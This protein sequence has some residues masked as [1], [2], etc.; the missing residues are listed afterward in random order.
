MKVCLLTSTYPLNSNDG[1]GHF[2]KSIA[3][4]LAGLGHEVHVVTPF[5][6]ELQAQDGK[7]QLHP[8]R[9]I[10]PDRWAIMGYGKSLFSDRSLRWGTYLL[11][12]VFFA[13]AVIKIIRLH[14]RYHFEI[15]HAHWVIPN[16]P[17][18]ALFSWLTNVP[19]IISLHGSDIF[20]ARQ[21]KWLGKIAGICF[22]RASA[23]TACSPALKEGAEAL[24]ADPLRTR[25]LL[26]G[27]DPTIFDP[28][29]MPSKANLRKRLEISDDAPVVLSLGRLVEKKGISTLVKAIPIVKEL[30]PKAMFIIAGDGTERDGLERLA[31]RLGVN[32]SI[33]FV[34]KVPWTNVAEYLNN[35]DIFCVPSIEDTE[36]NLDGLPTSILEAMSMG[37]V[38]IASNVAGIPLVIKNEQTGILV[39]PGNPEQ[40]GNTICSLLSNPIQMEYFGKNAQQRILK[41]LNWNSVGEIFSKLYITAD[42]VRLDV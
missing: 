31:E 25:L 17:A 38:V 27:A 28:A 13:S 42:K 18:A 15:I 23:I 33:R 40:L 2:I 37:K 8:F 32:E 9:Y 7:V 22:K 39:K 12:P 11:A 34:G 26:W 36:G 6:S 14:K 4:A 16:G 35:C 30:Q 41:E 20:V 3:E 1:S 19:L 29:K 10:W 24:G 5:Q 21:N